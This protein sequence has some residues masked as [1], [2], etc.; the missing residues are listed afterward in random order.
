MKVNRSGRRFWT[1]TMSP[2]IPARMFTLRRLWYPLSRKEW[3]LS[4]K[5]KWLAWAW[6]EPSQNFVQK[7][8]IQSVQDRWERVGHRWNNFCGPPKNLYNKSER[9]AFIAELLGLGLKGLICKSTNNHTTEKDK[10][11]QN[12]W[13]PS[14]QPGP[15]NL[16]RLPT[17]SSALAM[18]WC[19]HP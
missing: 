6:K 13:G 16:Y 1:T 4:R 7:R 11:M 19:N 8:L 17:P 2:T 9:P 12:S 18:F 5:H 3:G 15:G 14:G 10:T